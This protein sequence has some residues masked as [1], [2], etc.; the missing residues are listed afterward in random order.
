M[1][2]EKIGSFIREL[3]REKGLTQESLA[4]D[5]GVSQRSVSRWETGKTMPDYALLPAL[6]EILE[7]NAAELLN[8]R[9][10]EG[11]S[12]AKNEVTAATRT[13]IALAGDKKTLRRLLGAVIS[14]VLTIA[15]A[16]G[17]YAGEFSVSVDSTDELERA[18]NDYHFVAEVNADVL[19]RKALGS[20]L[21]VLY[22]DRDRPG[23]CGLACLEKG[24]LGGYR[25][26]SCDDSDERWIC[27]RAVTVGRRQ[28]C[29]SYGVNDLPGIDAYGIC[30]ML[31]WDGESA[32]T[33]PPGPAVLEEYTDAPFLHITEINKNMMLWTQRIRY[34]AQ[35]EEI[36][37]SEMRDRYGERGGAT[38]S[39]TGSAELWLFYVYEGLVFLLGFVFVRYFLL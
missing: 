34:Y 21:F 24:A 25:F 3:R 30:G 39:G 6:C 11:E 1:D 10:I 37:A 27:A 9:R 32:A 17:L 14:A 16:L 19:E 28:Y 13:L 2:Q 7:V 8:A 18:I 26:L 29:V 5:L 36:S 22:G 35:G 23:L 38:S 15:C 4:E 31:Y 20:R 33:D 12:V